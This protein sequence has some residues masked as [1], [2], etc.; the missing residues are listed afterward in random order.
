MGERAHAESVLIE[1]FR[2]SQQSQDEIAAANVM[3]EVAK[4]GAAV[5]VVAH[6][7]NDGAAVGVGL[8]PAQILLGRL[9]EFLQQQRPDVRLPSRIDDGLMGED[10]VC[11]NGG[12]QRQQNSDQAKQGRMNATKQTRHD[13][14]W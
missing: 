8:C 13:S 5:W 7:L 3:C 9:R 4:K 2:V 12:W 11:V 1:I 10:C 14:S 6:I